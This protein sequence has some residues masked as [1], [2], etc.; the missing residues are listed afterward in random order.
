MAGIRF[1][2]AETADELEQ[3]HRLN[4]QVFAEE[5][6]QH[7]KTADHLLIDRFHSSNQYFIA[8]DGQRLVGMVS[9]HAGPEFSIESRLA[10]RSL[11]RRLRAP[12]EV[13][14]LAVLPA[15]RNT[16][17][18]PGLLYQMYKYARRERYSDLLISGI[19][20]RREMYEKMGFHALGPAVPCGA[21][22][23]LPMI[24][25]L[26]ITPQDL[27]RLDRT[28]GARLRRNRAVSLLPG[29]V[30]IAPRVARAFHT[31]PFSHRSR[32]FL[33]VY[34]EVRSLLSVLM[35]GMHCAILSGSGTFANDAVAANLRAAFADAEGLVLVNG[36][37]GERLSRQATAA[38]LS[39]RTLSF[40]WGQSW[41]F[42][43]VEQEL[44][45]KPAWV[46][47]VHLETSTGV[48][49]DL[50]RLI[51]LCQTSAIPIAADCVSSMGA[52]EMNHT[53]GLFLASSVSGKA[54][55]AYAGLAFVFASSAALEQLD[56]KTFCPSFDLSKAIRNPGPVSTLSSPLV[57]AT[58]EALRLQYASP[59]ECQGRYR[60]H[61][62]LGQW[63]RAQIRAC[64]LAPLAPEAF[65]APNV[66]TFA[67]P[68]P[69]FAQE[70]KRAGFLIAYESHYL[71]SR[72]WGQMATM[73]NLNRH[74]L[75]SLFSALPEL[76]ITAH[77]SS[78]SH[79]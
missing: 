68:F 76:T 73:G 58:W 24:L 3:I 62:E 52:V 37:F 27:Q 13:R 15:Y 42:C 50:P 35:D 20:S 14:L 70:C 11:L 71:R 79:S 28:V 46:W 44:Q 40:G 45:R 51:N 56:G 64:G 23:F 72:N 36:E 18:L 17:L 26:D 59:A 22:S 25:P 48:L 33:A 16:F 9:V 61:Q 77:R 67:L 65:A 43:Q 49:N 12:L 75:E 7:P 4:H 1:K 38:G 5:I 60:H 57:S 47:A 53:S 63:M 19:I 39:F 78:A 8:L 69:D 10:D 54:L 31:P 29:P 55:G 30:E 41:D 21:A 32:R 2:Q 6:G 74:S 66:T 34:E